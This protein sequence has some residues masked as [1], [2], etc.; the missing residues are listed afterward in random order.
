MRKSD[1][2]L[3]R[4]YFSAENVQRL[5]PFPHCVQPAGDKA[6]LFKTPKHFPARTLPEDCFLP[7]SSQTHCR[8]GFGCLCVCLA[9]SASLRQSQQC[10]FPGTQ[11]TAFITYCPRLPQKCCQHYC[12]HQS[13]LLHVSTVPLTTAKK[14]FATYLFQLDGIKQQIH[15]Q[16]SHQT[17]GCANMG[18]RAVLRRSG[19]QQIRVPSSCHLSHTVW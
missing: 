11:R 5:F 16:L 13:P 19:W 10:P 17:F 1:I 6:F 14:V 2:F 3:M 4:S 7:F 8:C 9:L 18:K 15:K 12:L